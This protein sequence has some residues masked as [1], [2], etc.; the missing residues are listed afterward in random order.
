MEQH[1]QIPEEGA[2]RLAL[3]KSE[4]APEADDMKEEEVVAVESEKMPN[5]DP[6][7]LYRPASGPGI[8]L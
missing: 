6:L 1:L 2:S 5:A 8:L 3:K 4:K 7:R